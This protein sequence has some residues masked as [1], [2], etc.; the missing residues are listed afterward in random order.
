MLLQHSLKNSYLT[1]LL[2]LNPRFQRSTAL[3]ANI[4]EDSTDQQKLGIKKEK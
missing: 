4:P 2:F 3:S 1:V